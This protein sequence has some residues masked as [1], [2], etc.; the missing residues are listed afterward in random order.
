M[1]STGATF[2]VAVCLLTQACALSRGGNPGE[3]RSS[4][5][6]TG[7]EIAGST[8]RNAFELVEKLRPEWLRLRAVPRI[9]QEVPVLVVFLNSTRYG[10]AESLRDISVEMIGSLE[11]LSGSAVQAE[12]TRQSGRN[13]TA[14]I[15]VY[16]HGRA[17]EPVMAAN[18]APPRTD[19]PTVQITVY[20]LATVTA[21]EQ[22]G[23]AAAFSRAGWTQ[24]ARSSDPGTAM[25]SLRLGLRDGTAGELIVSRRFGHRSETFRR[26]H[27]IINFEESSMAVAGLFS[28]ELKVLR[29]GVGYGAEFTRME[30]SLG[31]CQCTSTGLE[32]RVLRGMWLDMSAF[33]PVFS[34]LFGEVR[35]QHRMTP[36]ADQRMYNDVPALQHGG[37]TWV[38]G[39]GGG[40]R[41]LK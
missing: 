23:H 28:Y 27:G 39:V 21:H 3:G 25:A 18:A 4:S 30:W 40:V 11:Y 32:K 16:S 38:V 7:D 5:R 2:L 14:V 29:A 6:I 15:H 36:F 17:A 35:V 24:S 8:A 1:R 19:L 9:G 33:V 20:P 10:N 41:L 12:F 31:E 22:P 34:R 26:N 37:A 13:V